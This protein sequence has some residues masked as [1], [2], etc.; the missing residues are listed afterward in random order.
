[1]SKSRLTHSLLAE[2]VNKYRNINTIQ[3]TLLHKR[4]I[5]SIILFESFVRILV[6]KFY[7][8]KVTQKLRKF[9]LKIDFKQIDHSWDISQVKN[10][11]IL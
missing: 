3:K 10:K 1:M 2:D 5:W 4:R 9:V 8:Q 11:I 6:F 7:L